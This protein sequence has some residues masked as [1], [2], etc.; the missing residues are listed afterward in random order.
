MK[1]NSRDKTILIGLLTFIIVIAGI[2]GLI[3]PKIND[4]KDD[5]AALKKTKAEW[6]ELDAKIKEIKP[7]QDEIKK[8]YEDSKKVSAE[9]MKFDIFEEENGTY[10]TYKLDQYMQPIIDKCELEVITEDLG[11]LTTKTL[12]YYYVEPEVVSTSMFDLADVNGNYQAAVDEQLAAS[13]ALGERTQEELKTIQYGFKAKGTRENI[14]AFMDEIKE[15]KVSGLID[16][17]NIDDYTF[18]E[19]D[20]TNIGPDAD[21]S[22]VTFVISFYSVYEMDEPVVD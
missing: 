7:L 8:T 6:E 13:N 16:S 2:F 4:V 3:R 19:D 14:W 20:P 11:S 22:E 18:G 21:K 9:F 15:L 5:E 12:G 10:R 1:M 17:V